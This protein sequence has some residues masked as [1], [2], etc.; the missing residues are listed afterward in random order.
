M[1]STSFLDLLGRRRIGE[2]N[3]A[4]L[5]RVGPDDA[6]T[7]GAQKPSGE[8]TDQAEPDHED[9]RSRP[10]SCEPDRV[11]GDRSRSSERGVV[12]THV[13][14][15]RNDEVYRYR[16]HLGVRRV[17]GADAR[18]PHA[19]HQPGVAAAVEHPTREAVAKSAVLTQPTAD[20]RP[21]G[22]DSLRACDLDRLAYEIRPGTS[23]LEE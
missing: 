23:L 6:A 10:D 21:R 4:I 13:L 15:Q 3:A 8:L 12:V 7:R 9:D 20:L 17:T 18:H 1:A 11:Q 22:G 14:G 2:E 16:N 19:G 5:A